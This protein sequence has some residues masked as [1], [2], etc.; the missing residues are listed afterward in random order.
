MVHCSSIEEN[1]VSMRYLNTESL[2]AF[3]G[4]REDGYEGTY[5]TVE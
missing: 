2:S 1:S 4:Y 3:Y 5:E